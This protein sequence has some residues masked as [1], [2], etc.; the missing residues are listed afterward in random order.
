MAD[1]ENKFN[2]LFDKI[3]K[4][5]ASLNKFQL[6]IVKEVAGKPCKAHSSR[7]GLLTWLTVILIGSVLAAAAAVIFKS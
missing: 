2:I 5:S 4:L 6:D 1:I 7:L 3:D